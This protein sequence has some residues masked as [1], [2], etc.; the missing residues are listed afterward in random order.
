GGRRRPRTRAKVISHPRLNWRNPGF[1]RPQFEDEPVVQV[2][3]NDA[4][5]FCEWLSEREGVKYRLPTEAEWEYACR[6][7]GEGRWCFGDDPAGLN[8]YAWIEANSQS[9]A[10]PVGRRYPSAF[11][12]HDMHGNVRVWRTAIYKLGYPTC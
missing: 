2:C 9:I 11:G 4:V 1:R 5:A 6:A 7:G 12:L 3:W 8:H 10:R